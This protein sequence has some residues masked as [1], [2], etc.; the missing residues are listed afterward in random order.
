MAS[1][2]ITER[3]LKKLDNPT[4]LTAEQAWKL[5]KGDGSGEEI[6]IEFIKSVCEARRISLDADG[7][8]K[9]LLKHHEKALLNQKNTRKD[10]S[11]FIDLAIQLN[12]LP[13]TD[14]SFKYAFDLDSQGKRA[15]FKSSGE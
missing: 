1:E 4:K 7:L 11:K 6:S 10:N 14:N 2:Q 13:K 9:I 12:H 5:F 8:E 3:Y 15:T